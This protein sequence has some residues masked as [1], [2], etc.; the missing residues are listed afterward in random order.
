MQLM[1]NQSS[2]GLVLSRMQAKRVPKGFI[3]D[4]TWHDE[5]IN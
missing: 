5:T 3:L 4:I 1:Q 2:T